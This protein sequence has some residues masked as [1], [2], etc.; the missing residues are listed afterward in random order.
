MKIIRIKSF[1]L[2][3][4]KFK[5]SSYITTFFTPLGKVSCAVRGA[6]RNK[7]KFSGIIQ[8]YNLLEIQF[9]E[10]PAGK[11]SPLIEA[12]LLNQFPDIL[13]SFEKLTFS[14]ITVETINLFVKRNNDSSKLFEIFL[15]YLD[16]QNRL[17][18][19]N[20]SINLI[21]WFLI[22]LLRIE[23]YLPMM[24]DGCSKCGTTRASHYY[25]T[26][27]DGLICEDC[28][29]AMDTPENNLSLS[30]LKVLEKQITLP[31]IKSAIFMVPDNTLIVL[32]HYIENIAE[33]KLNSLE[34]R[35]ENRN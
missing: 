30:E 28:T 8:R 22:N 7:N 29:D 2:R 16:A 15:Q 24:T 9:P 11:L 5:E 14:E 6:R 3:N 34:L 26:V 35:Y 21:V 17:S 23:G 25:I 33:K 31:A 19:L 12:T 27:T 13:T 10:K 32:A 1:V 4:I 18:D 20:K